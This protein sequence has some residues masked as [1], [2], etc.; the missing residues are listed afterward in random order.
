[1]TLGGSNTYTGGTM[2]AG[3]TLVVSSDANLGASSAELQ[4]SGGG[5]SIEV[6]TLRFGASFNLNG[7]RAVSIGQ[8]VATIDTNGFST[9]ISQGIQNGTGGLVKAGIGTLVLGGQSTYAGGT[10]VNA[11]TLQLAAGASLVG[12]GSLTVNGGAFDLN[13]NSQTVT[14]L[15]GTGG[16]ITLGSG[17]L[18]TSSSANASLA[19]IISGADP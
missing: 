7:A 15:S 5:N 6:G 10:T 19:S 12:A 2:L 8:G 16:A 14:A 4:L 18:T 17:S 13:G 9:T 3:G 1:M 11:G